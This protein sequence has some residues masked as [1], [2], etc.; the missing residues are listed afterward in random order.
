MKVA[1]RK[2]VKPKAPSHRHA[3]ALIK[4][5]YPLVAGIDEVGRGCWAGPV[6]AAAVILRPGTRKLVGVNDSKLLTHA[7]RLQMARLIKQHALA[8]GI[9][10]VHSADIDANGLTWA[11]RQSGLRAL[12]HM[13]HPYHAVLLDGNHNYLREHCYSQTIIKGDQL[14]ISIA[15]ASIVAK[16][17][18]DQYME[19]QHRLYPDYDFASNKGYGTPRHAEAVRQTLT[20]LH[21]RLF[22]PVQLASQGFF[23]Q[24]S[25]DH[26][27]D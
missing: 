17:A 19:L 23:E 27:I 2:P 22:K 7:R 6:V 10:W 11:V 16:V 15:A 13:Q 14:S 21:R 25:F 20:P 24:L 26:V 18:R 8:V 5:G 3:A 4:A 9:G 12:D 1:V